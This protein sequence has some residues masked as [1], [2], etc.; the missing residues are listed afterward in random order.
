M[1]AKRYWLTIIVL[2]LV[3]GGATVALYSAYATDPVE[4]W[5][6]QLYRKVTVTIRSL[7]SSESG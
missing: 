7:L 3:V 4:R 2:A 5:L 1:K 6:Q